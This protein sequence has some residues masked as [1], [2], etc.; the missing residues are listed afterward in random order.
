MSSWTVVEPAIGVLAG[1][2]PTLAP[3]LNIRVHLKNLSSTLRSQFTSR[4]RT[5][6]SGDSKS[7]QSQYNRELDGLKLRPDGAATMVPGASAKRSANV[8]EDDD[9]IPLHSIVVRQDM[10]TRETRD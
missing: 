8:D 1:C 2:I 10:D 9:L 7:S 3:L 4:G 5:P 6:R